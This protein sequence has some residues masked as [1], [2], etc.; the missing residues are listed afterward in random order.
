MSRRCILL[1]ED[2]GFYILN[3]VCHDFI[4]DFNNYGRMA[5]ILNYIQALVSEA[6]ASR[7]DIEE[8]KS[9]IVGITDELK[10]AESKDNDGATKI[11]PDI[12]VLEEE[13][14]ESKE[15]GSDDWKTLVQSQEEQ[16][17]KSSAAE[18]VEKTIVIPDELREN[19]A[20]VNRSIILFGIIQERLP[21]NRPGTR[22]NIKKI[23]LLQNLTEF[24]GE[25]RLLVISK[26]S[27]PIMMRD[28]VPISRVGGSEQQ[29]GGASAIDIITNDDIV[30]L[31]FGTNSNSLSLISQPHN[32]LTCTPSLIEGNLISFISLFFL[33]SSSAI[34]YA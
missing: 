24:I 7:A 23:N 5:K 21:G 2:L 15:D 10:A 3:A 27:R 8:I 12:L 19:Q 26:I 33:I 32:C 16:Y 11:E 1:P 22:A 14:P 20:I 28:G 18:D 34:R 31:H 30:V 6:S 29:K 9:S 17:L 4:H 13:E 25:S